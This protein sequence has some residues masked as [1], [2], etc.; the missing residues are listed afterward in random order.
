MKASPAD[1]RRLVEVA[2]LDDRIRQADAARRNPPQAARV[3][4]LLTHRQ[5]LAQELASRLGARDDLR[6]ELSRIESDV[7][8]VDARASRD[9]GRLA[10]ERA[11]R[12]RRRDSRANWR[13]SRGGRAISRMPSS[14]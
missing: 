2:E 10:S 6:I 1:Q 7:A 5:Q 12:R 9:A 11:T 4:E 13:R 8:V 14:R 3:Q